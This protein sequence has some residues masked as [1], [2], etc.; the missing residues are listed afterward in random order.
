MTEQQIKKY[1]QH[2]NFYLI[3]TYNLINGFEIPIKRDIIKG[4]C[5]IKLN[6]SNTL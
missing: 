2:K 1:K 5:S 3:V 4:L 6:Y